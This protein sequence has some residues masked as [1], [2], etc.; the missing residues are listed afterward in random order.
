MGCSAPLRFADPQSVFCQEGR[1]G[2]FVAGKHNP[3]LAGFQLLCGQADGQCAVGI[4]FGMIEAQDRMM[5]FGFD[6]KTETTEL[7]R[8]HFDPQYEAPSSRRQYR[9]VWRHPDVACCLQHNEGYI[10]LRP[11]S[12]SKLRLQ[13]GDRLALYAQVRRSLAEL[14]TESR[15]LEKERPAYND[16][17]SHSDA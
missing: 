12:R 16:C 13:G 7:A 2:W 9:L 10:A 3:K 1:G 4:A 17:K 11:G 15:H 14:L 6:L 5:I 8:R